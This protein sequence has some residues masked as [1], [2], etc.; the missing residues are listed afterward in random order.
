MQNAKQLGQKL[1]VENIVDKIIDKTVRNSD[2]ADRTLASAAAF[3]ICPRIPAKTE[4]KRA[5][6]RE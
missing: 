5:L 1:N 2:S 6:N 4:T 3:I